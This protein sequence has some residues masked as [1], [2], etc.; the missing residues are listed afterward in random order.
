MI[1]CLSPIL[2]SNEDQITEKA[3][4]T[5]EMGRALLPKKRKWQLKFPKEKRQFWIFQRQKDFFPSPLLS[6]QGYIKRKP[7]AKSA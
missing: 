3:L 1:V 2:K 5:E 7:W 4:E 6:L